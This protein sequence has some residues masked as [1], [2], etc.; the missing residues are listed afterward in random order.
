MLKVSSG[1][2]GLKKRVDPEFLS[3]AFLLPPK[4]SRI[5]E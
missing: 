1:A 2:E 5:F 4:N 3:G